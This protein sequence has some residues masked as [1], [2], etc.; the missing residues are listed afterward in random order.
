MKPSEADAKFGSKLGE[1]VSNQHLIVRSETVYTIK[2]YA[3]DVTYNTQGFTEKNLDALYDTLIDAMKSSKNSWI[4]SF[5][6]EETGSRTKQ[7]P[8]T[9]GIFKYL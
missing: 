9:S 1:A 5:F 2:H 7:K 6:P 4:A 8:T 3:G